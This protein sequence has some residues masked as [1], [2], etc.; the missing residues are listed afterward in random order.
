MPEQKQDPWETGFKRYFSPYREMRERGI[1]QENWL[2]NLDRMTDSEITAMMNIDPR[3]QM[4]EESRQANPSITD[5]QRA[6]G[7]KY[8]GI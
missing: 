1:T 5:R 3:H 7:L 4:W 8:F 2:D 6:E